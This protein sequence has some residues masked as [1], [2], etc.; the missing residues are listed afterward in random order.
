M[1]FCANCAK[2]IAQNKNF[3]SCA[4]FSK[5]ISGFAQIAQKKIAQNSLRFMRKNSAK[6]RKFCAKDCHFVETLD[7][8]VRKTETRQIW[9]FQVKTKS[10][11]VF[12]WLIQ[13][14]D[15]ERKKLIVAGNHDYEETESINSV[16]SSLKSH[17]F[18]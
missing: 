18:G 6:V 5:N 3:V 13:W 11:V 1:R 15:K 8:T 4:T 2:K 10:S 7:G 9:Q 12:R 17:F 14:Y 16:Q